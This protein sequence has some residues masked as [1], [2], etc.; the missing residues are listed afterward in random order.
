MQ[1][2]AALCTYPDPQSKNYA[3]KTFFLRTHV[4]LAHMHMYIVLL[5][6]MYITLLIV[7]HINNLLVIQTTC[8]E[9]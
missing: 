3:G 7:F 6:T 8:Y 2:R 1:H 9:L 5:K 4:D